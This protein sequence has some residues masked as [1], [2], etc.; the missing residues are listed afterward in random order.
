MVKKP[1]LSKELNE[2]LIGL[3]L[4]QKLDILHKW[5]KQGII[6]NEIFNFYSRYWIEKESKKL[7]SDQPLRRTPKENF[8][9]RC[10]GL[11]AEGEVQSFLD[12][13]RSISK[14]YFIKPS[15]SGVV[16]TPRELEKFKKYVK[17]YFV[18]LPDKVFRLLIEGLRFPD[19]SGEINAFCN[20][21]ITS[22]PRDYYQET[23]FWFLLW[24]EGS[25]VPMDAIRL[26]LEK[27]DGV[28]QINKRFDVAL[29]AELLPKFIIHRNMEMIR[30]ENAQRLTGAERDREVSR[31]IRRLEAFNL[32]ISSAEKFCGKI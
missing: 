21:W 30:L 5:R 28:Y 6:A 10:H 31:K 29:I 20:K 7:R 11:A 16:I 2:E 27:T 18:L 12:Y 14:E 8:D 25:F 9:K 1:K 15:G 26:M 22:C 17:K 23:H 24:E 3:T 4:Q 13:I 19:S 32:L